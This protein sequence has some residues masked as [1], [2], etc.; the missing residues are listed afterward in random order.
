MRPLPDTEAI[1]GRIRYLM[2]QTGMSQAAFAKRLSID[3]SN[4]SKHLSGRLAVSDTL[5]NRIVA[6][7]GV[8]KRWL[9]D[10]HGLPYDPNP[11]PREITAST[12]RLLPP[13]AEGT[14]VYDIDVTAGC[15]ELSSMFTVDRVIGTM[16]VPHLDSRSAIVGVRGDSMEPI[17][18]DGG[19]IAIRRISDRSV[20]YWGQIYVVVLDDYRMVK[21]LRRHEDPAMVIL[22]SA[23]PDYDDIEVARADIRALYL[24]ESILR[25]A[26]SPLTARL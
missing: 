10:G 8:S 7:M 16:R 15:A 17:I 18:A 14:P 23:N 26:P 21:S 20:I 22:R 5:V 25:D 19:A 2:A 3:P 1:V 4:L 12:C 9:R 13:G 11:T 24:V 6:D